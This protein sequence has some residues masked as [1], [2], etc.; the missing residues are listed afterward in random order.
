[1]RERRYPRFASRRLDPARTRRITPGAAVASPLTW[2]NAD[3]DDTIGEAAPASG[4]S[5]RSP[6]STSWGTCSGGDSPSSRCPSSRG[7]S[8]RPDTG[9]SRSWGPCKACSRCSTR[10]VSPRLPRASTTTARDQDQRQEALRHPARPVARRDHGADRSALRPRPVAVEHGHPGC[11]VLPL[12]RPDDRHRAPRQH[13]HPSP[14]ALSRSEPGLDVLPAERRPNG[15]D[16]G[17]VGL[18]RR[19]RELSVPPD[20]SWRPSSPRRSSP[21]S[22]PIICARTSG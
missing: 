18:A 12:R 6:G 8:L 15:S 2:T 14:G 21:R 19:R 3:G 5:S 1:M 11:S 10:W 17:P 7:T 20:R 22:T 13:R 9:S 4:S 16:R